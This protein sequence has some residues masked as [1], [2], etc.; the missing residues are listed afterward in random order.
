LTES[1]VDI[2]FCLYSLLVVLFDVQKL[3]HSWLSALSEATLWW[4]SS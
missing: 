2:M 4:P 1:V 3:V